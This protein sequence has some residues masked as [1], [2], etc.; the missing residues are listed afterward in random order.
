MTDPIVTDPTLPTPT[1]AGAATGDNWQERVAKLEEENKALLREKQGI[2]ADVKEERRK[3]Q[4]AEARLVTPPVAVDEETKKAKQF[5]HEAAAELINP[6]RMELER[7]KA[8]NW[9]AKEESKRTGKAVFADDIETSPLIA[10][11]A[12]IEAEK[13]LAGMGLVK[14]AQTSYELLLKERGDKERAAK[15]SEASRSAAIDNNASEDT[16]STPSIQGKRKWTNSDLKALDHRA[17]DFDAK[18]AEVRL[19]IA[20][21]RFDKNK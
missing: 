18:M 3:R 19:A 13:G 5:V 9:L 20:E 17:P 8:L 2:Y 4:E 10:D 21:G 14:S 1:P 7:T 12:R 16:R 15:A 6:L 11:L